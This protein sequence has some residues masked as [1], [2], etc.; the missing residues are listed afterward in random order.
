MAAIGLVEQTKALQHIGNHHCSFSLGVGGFKG[1]INAL[2]NAAIREPLHKSGDEVHI[3]FGV[4]AQR[5]LWT[6]PH[7]PLPNLGVPDWDLQASLGKP[8]IRS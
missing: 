8:Q 4:L 7:R 3:E 5:M 1:C 2:A 6:L